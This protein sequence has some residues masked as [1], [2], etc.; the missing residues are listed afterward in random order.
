MSASTLFATSTGTVWYSAS[1]TSGRPLPALAA[2]SS[3]VTDGSPCAI[4]IWRTWMSGWLLFQIATV[5]SM[6]VA[7]DQN[8][9]ST[10]WSPPPAPPEHPAVSSVAATTVAT[11]A[12]F[13]NVRIRPP[14]DV[15]DRDHSS[16]PPATVR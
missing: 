5:L 13:R 6:L 12:L 4:L 10:F 9:S 3:L 7:H 14:L 16:G 2:A 8:V 11:A 15:R 1:V